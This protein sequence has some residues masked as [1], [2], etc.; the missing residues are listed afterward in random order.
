VIARWQLRDA[1]VSEA[2]IGRWVRD[3]RLCRRRHGVYTVGHRILSTRGE[4][5]AALLCAGRGAVLSH[6]TAA[7]W[8]GLLAAEPRRIHVSAPTQR[9]STS[10]LKVHRPRRLER[11]VHRGLPVTPVARTVL[12]SAPGLGSR[13]LRKLL[14][15]VEFQGLASLEEVEAAATRGH[16]GSAALRRALT[17]HRPELARARTPL[18]ERFVELCEC[19]DIPMPRLNEELCGFV[20]DAVWLDGLVVELDGRAGHATGARM[21]ADRRRDLALRA[22]GFDVWR[23]TWSQLT[24]SASLIADEVKRRLR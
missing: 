17:A 14:A 9:R 13:A 8:W 5:L 3:A 19:Y 11:V 24:D 1:G 23:Y 21:E 6:V 2:R 4:L 16:P 7:W 22:A 20:V 15:E 18:E 10:D 12:D